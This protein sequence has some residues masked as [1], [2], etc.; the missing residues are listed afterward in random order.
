M[1]VPKVV[2]QWKTYCKRKF[3]LLEVLDLFDQVIEAV[4]FLHS[5]DFIHR[6][7][8]PSRIQQFENGVIKFNTVGLPYNFK[9]LL[10]RDDFSGHINYSAPELILERPDFSNKIDIWAIGCCLFYVLHK[11]DPF[12]GKDP[13]E[14]K[15]KIIDFNLEKMPHVEEYAEARNLLQAC[16]NFED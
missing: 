7:V 4:E 1:E 2:S 12:D 5:N 3:S 8:H 13:S 16:F 6:D 14:V 10:K 9:K 15:R 11:K